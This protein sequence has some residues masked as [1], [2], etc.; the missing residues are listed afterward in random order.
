ME[1]KL[2]ELMEYENIVIQC[3][4][5]P[6]ADALAS[7]YALKW[8]LKLKGKDAR[9][10][11]SGKLE[12]RKSNLLKMI[13][14][15]EIDVEYVKEMPA[16]DLLLTVDCQYGESNVTHFDAEKIAVIDHHQVSREL[17]ELSVVRSNYG[18][19]STVIYELLRNEGIDI[20]DDPKVSTALYYGLLTDTSNFVEISHPA[21]RDLRDNAGFVNFQ[22]TT[23]RNSNISKDELLIA[24]DAL[25]EAE[26]SDTY[27]FGIVET[28]PCDPNI[29]GIISDMLLEVEGVDSC[30]VYTIFDFGV[31]ISVRSCTKLI[32]ANEMAEFLSDGY[33]GGGG[34]ISKAGGLLK[35]D[36]MKRA[37]IS[38]DHDTITEYLR[39]RMIEYH[40][41]CEILYAGKADED[42]SEYEHYVKKDV[43]VGYV[44]AQKI[45]EPGRK[46]CIRTLE[47][48]IEVSVDTD[49]IIILGIEGEVYP[50]NRAK[51]EKS[52]RLSDEPYIFPGEYPP[53][54]IDSGSGE[55]IELLPLASSCITKGGAG[56]YAKKLDH[57]IKIFTTWDPD[58]YFLGVEGDYKA[59]RAD[60]H[61]DVYIIAA[62]VF[63]KSYTKA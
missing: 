45:A 7:G 25:K 49:V 13:E 53:V 20:N 16:P 10:I 38:Y 43:K 2:S 56:I 48:D 40:R 63:A 12:I 36:M 60:D 9:F 35:K 29:L 57:R 18:S 14:L 17:P 41:D 32:K 58:R 6:D 5:N 51:F 22:I 15:F 27:T 23:L 54:V 50:M 30:L 4:D 52:Y 26:F 47:G 39:N 33:G 37:G 8:Y 59:V 31:K 11:Y 62:D 42:I 55:R 46:V 44:E 19:C 61:K 28:R 24:G 34:H 21:D 3:H 1:F